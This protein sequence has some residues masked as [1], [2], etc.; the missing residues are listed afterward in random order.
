MM[1][2]RMTQSSVSRRV[3]GLCSVQ[4]AWL[5]GGSSPNLN[6]KV[7]LV[8]G[9]GTG[10]GRQSSLALAAAG[11]SVVLAGRRAEPLAETAELILRY[12]GAKPS[13]VPTDLTN[14]A[15]IGELF[16][17][18]EQ[19]HGRLDILFN[20]AGVGAPAVP[21]DELP[22]EKWQASVDTNITAMFICTQ[23]AFR[24]MKKQSPMGGRIINNGSVSADRPRPNSAPYTAT[25]HAVTGL[26]K[27]CALDGRPF[28]IACGQID[29]G[30]ADTALLAGMK[31]SDSPEA[32]MDVADV[33]RALVYMASLPL[34]A[35]VLFMTVMATNMPLIGR[36]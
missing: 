29:V 10:I 23:H 1:L 21:I 28:S 24:M 8:T 33:G 31:A 5:S 17:S 12:G 3:L 2:S 7:A 25:K 26:T 34:E 35:N 22:L 15:A 19:E 30:N 36:G 13:V 11:A 6:G 27:S 14:P 4:R 9:A 16:E 32:T 18:I 20:N